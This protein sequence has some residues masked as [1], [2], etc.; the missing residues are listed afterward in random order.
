[1]TVSLDSLDLEAA[2]LGIPSFLFSVSINP[3]DKLRL[4]KIQS[5]EKTLN[6]T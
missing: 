6:I 3:H 5:I 4:I 2:E 1:M